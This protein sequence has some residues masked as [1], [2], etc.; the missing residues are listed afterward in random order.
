MDLAAR[1]AGDSASDAKF[2][3]TASVWRSTRDA[4]NDYL[5]EVGTFKPYASEKQDAVTHE[6]IGDQSTTVKRARS[7]ETIY[8]TLVRYDNLVLSS[9]LILPRGSQPLSPEAFSRGIRSALN[10]IAGNI[11]KG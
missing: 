11:P 10:G 9:Q 1:D 7:A 8:I 6:S 4:R 2:Q 5:G 3:F